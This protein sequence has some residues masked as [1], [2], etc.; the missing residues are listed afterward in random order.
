MKQLKRFQGSLQTL[1]NIKFMFDRIWE[2]KDGKVYIF[3]RI[4]VSIL[5]SL[6]PLAETVLP[7]LIINE[8]VYVRIGGKLLF[9]ITA[10][11]MIPLLRGLLK[12]VTDGILMRLAEEINE[13]NWED[14]YRFINRIDY[15]ILELPDTQDL[16][17][18]ADKSLNDETAVIRQF[19]Q[20]LSAV[21]N[22]FL[23]SSIIA[24][25]NPLI[26]VLAIIT[27]LTNSVVTKHLNEKNHETDNRIWDKL[28]RQWGFGWMLDSFDY[29][30][31][32]R[33]FQMGELLIGKFMGIERSI[34][35]DR[36]K[37]NSD[38]HV[39]AVQAAGL[40]FFYLAILY[41]YLIYRVIQEGLEVGSMAIF[42]SAAGRFS[43]SLGV[44]MDSYVSLSAISLRVDDLRAFLRMP[45]GQCAQGKLMPQCGENSIIEFRN[46]SFRY[47]GS[48]QNA[49]SHL[50]LV[51]R[52][53]EKLCIVGENGAG[54]STF[55][56]LLM[57]LYRPSEGEILLNGININEYDYESYQRMFAPVF[58]DCAEFY[59]TLGEN[60]I[61]GDSWD[62][63][64]LDNV[65]G[66]SGVAAFMEKLP[67]G[68]NTQI[69]K[70]FDENAIVPSGGECQKIA[71]ARACYH[72]GSIYLL[73]E[74]TAAL[75]PNA[76]YEMYQQF[77]RMT[78]GKYTIF[79]THRLSAVQ[80]AD[81]IAVFANGGIAE[82]GTHASLY[83][84]G[85]LYTV[86]FDKQAEF[87]RKDI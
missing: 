52:C 30:K 71:I 17:N 20:M 19:A 85:G 64:K 11:L 61:L 44:V 56:K 63:K 8:L 39:A 72:G 65:C 84:K 25:L 4:S 82:Y 32:L 5:E 53:N 34:N 48:G 41:G 36:K 6:F 22:V 66:F 13:K 83:R 47:H 70:W 46:V 37:M 21:L 15:E 12:Y 50:N 33:L 86:M 35:Q 78:E 74:P 24:M 77:D 55:I 18:R 59:L 23:L 69:K 2:Q 62:I 43:A 87:Y 3:L 81:R 28:R 76:E 26:T 57:R 38:Q 14:F 79:I 9:L 60:I 16:K 51:L 27:I 31:E 58:Q 54:K 10:L 75:D 80:L 7:G 29:A 49:I 42:L 45:T 40:R 67:E 73:D 68:Y 1:G